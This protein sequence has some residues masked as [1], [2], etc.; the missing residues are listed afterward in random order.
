[1]REMRVMFLG[2]LT[3][4]TIGLAYLLAVALRHA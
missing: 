2:Y 1:V 3:V 4:I